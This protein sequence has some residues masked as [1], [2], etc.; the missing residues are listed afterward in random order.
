MAASGWRYYTTG[1]EAQAAMLA[2][3]AGAERSI[4]LEQF[5][6]DDDI[7]GRQFLTTLLRRAQSGVRVR[8]LCDAIGS[9]D[10]IDSAIVRELGAAGIQFLFFNPIRR[11]WKHPFSEWFLRDH[12]KIVVVDAIVGFI[13]GVGIRDEMSSWRD[14]HARVTG[15]TVAQLAESFECFWQMTERHRRFFSLP[16]PSPQSSGFYLLTNAPYPRQR[17]MYRE[18]L[19]RIRSAARYVYLTTPYFVPNR[20]L[21]RAI[22][23]AARRGVEVRLLVPEHVNHRIVDIAGRS[24]YEGLLRAGVHVHQYRGDF[25]HAK[26][27]IIDDAW[28]TL[29]ST[30]LDNLSM[31]LN[32]EANIATKDRECVEELGRQFLVDLQ[33]SIELSYEN[34]RHRPLFGQFLEL[35]I[36]PIHRLL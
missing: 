24:Y 11:W 35:L 23:S 9:D 28:A 5:I 22:R 26:G 7:I 33:Q 2:A 31:L 3:C 15:D 18:L 29:G 32:Y 27:I 25:L 17:F 13:G 36:M 10:L 21:L 4:D 6:F 16:K 20:P 14:T 30:N 19:L 1:E 12:R 34:W 8:V